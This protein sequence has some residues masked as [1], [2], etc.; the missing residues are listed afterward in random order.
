MELFDENSLH[1]IPP[2][3]VASPRKNA[4]R[5]MTILQPILEPGEHISVEEKHLYKRIQLLIHKKKGLYKKE[6]N[7]FHTTTVLY[8]VVTLIENWLELLMEQTV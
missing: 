2:R 7:I 4:F 3:D 5:F 6:G 8:N 1:V